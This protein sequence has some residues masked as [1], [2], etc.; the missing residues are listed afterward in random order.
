MSELFAA[1]AMLVCGLSF[2]IGIMLAVMAVLPAAVFQ[3][4]PKP[5]EEQVPFV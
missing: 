5:I 3:H 1:I 4:I 2:T